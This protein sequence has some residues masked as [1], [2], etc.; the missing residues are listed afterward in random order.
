MV[1]N[2]TTRFAFDWWII[3]KRFVYLMIAI[4]LACGVAGGAALYVWKYGNPFKNVAQMN[5]PAGARF[6]SF[7]GDVRVIRAAT[8]ETIAA[9]ADTQLYPGDTVQTQTNGRARIGL[10]D[11]STLVVK[12]NSTIIVRNNARADDGKRTNVHVSVESGQLSVRTEQQ[13][14]GTTNVVETPKTKNTVGESTNA[15][16]GVNPEGTEEIRVS[17]GGVESTNSSGEKTSIRG[18]EYVSVNNSGRL[19][20]AQ[21]LLDVPHPSQPHDLEKVF[22]GT[23]GAA[24]VALKW[25]RPQSGTPAYYRV[26]VATS[27]FFVADGKV[28]ERDQLLATEFGASDLRPGVYFWRVRASASSGQTS[29]WS[30]PLKFIVATRGTGSQVAVSNLSAELLGGSLYLVRGR[31]EPGTTIKVS[32]RETIV[33]PDGSFQIQVTASGGVRDVTVEAQDP[34]GNSSQY[35]VSLSGRTAR[36]RT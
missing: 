5:Y 33:A 17:T 9:N 3:E 32:G 24:S 4:F 31:A 20:A 1:A 23:N 10:A 35:K 22:V 7:E 26:E 15:S 16:F 27:P 28:I 34:H 29:D 6:I 8:R 19:S 36:G 2:K 11:G 14:D 25:Q 13:A 12:P 21:R 30:D 18:G